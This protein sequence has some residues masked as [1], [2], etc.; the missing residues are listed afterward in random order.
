[1]AYF[2]SGAFQRRLRGIGD[3][4]PDR[5]IC[6]RYKPVIVDNFPIRKVST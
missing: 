5:E 4:K 3:V 1:M 6:V 2:P